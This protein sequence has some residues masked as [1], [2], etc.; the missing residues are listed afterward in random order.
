MYNTRLSRLIEQASAAGFHAAGL[1][2]GP[3]LFY[4][5][6][7][8]FHLSER[9]VVALFPVQGT[10]AIVLP[11]LEA[12]KIETTTVEM[13]PFPYTD[14]EGHTDAFQRACAALELRDRVIGVEALRMRLLEVRLLERYAPGSRILPAEDVL[15]ELRMCKDEQEL[16]H[17]RRAVS[18]VEAALGATMRQVKA[19]M[20]EREV[21]G[22]LTMHMLQ[23]GGEALAF[24]PIVVAGPNAASP[25]AVPSDRAIQ[26]GETIV[27][28][29]GVTVGGYASDITRTFA[30]GEL[31][32]E[33]A[34]VY[35][36]VR[37]ANEAGRAAA[38]P[39]VP[40]E[41]VDRAARQVIEAAG[42]GPHFIHRTGHGLGLETHEPPYIVAGNQR[43][44]QPGM[45][46]TVEPGIYLPGR[47]GVRI[48]DDV[49]ITD[50]GAA[51]LTTFPRHFTPLG[52]T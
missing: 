9:P 46:F 43:R 45:T 29:C 44:L 20:T 1:M 31:A 37:A 49:V 51:S 13:T 25:H 15:A 5:T 8:S 16:T 28:D 22:L 23:A 35:E 40:A 18:R 26:P 19:G 12:A 2:P 36:A 21:A 47:G 30:I 24:E 6:G 4:L 10:P 33:L 39:G 17:M 32:P 27:V 52:T 11:A 34:A 38:G 48:E 42:Y 41:N 3:N 7:L 50:D 14:E